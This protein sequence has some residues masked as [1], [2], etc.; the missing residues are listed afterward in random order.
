MQ[1][2]PFLRLCYVLEGSE[3]GY[4]AWRK[5]EQSERKQADEALGKRIEDAYQNNRR[6]YGNPCVHAVLQK[7]V[8][9]CSRIRN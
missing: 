9:H 5:R 4:Y 6:V 8:V 3:S 7:Q 2:F 1:E